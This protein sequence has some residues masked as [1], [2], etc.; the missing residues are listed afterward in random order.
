MQK[1]VKN[2]L[3]CIVLFLVLFYNSIHYKRFIAF[4]YNFSNIG[5]FSQVMFSMTSKKQ[6]WETL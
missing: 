1:V 6:D 3:K 5:E 2:D 4:Y